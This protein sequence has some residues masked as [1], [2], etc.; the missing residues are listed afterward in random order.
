MK[1]PFWERPPTLAPVMESINSPFLPPGF[2]IHTLT[3][4]GVDKAQRLVIEAGW[5]QTPQDWI[6]FLELGH[7]YQVTT[8]EGEIVA[9]AATLPYPP[10][11][12]WIS[13]VLVSQKHRRQGIASALL[14]LCI[15]T[16]RSANLAPCLDATQAGRAVY[17]PLGFRDGLSISRWR[18][19]Q[20]CPALEL[21]PQSPRVRPLL[22]S[23]WPCI[24][25]LDH[26]AFG[27]DRTA[28]LNQLH[29]R[30]TSFSCVAEQNGKV[31][32]FLLGRVGRTAT[33]I[34]PLVAL[35]ENTALALLAFALP[36]VS[37]RVL[38]DAIDLHGGLRAQLQGLGFEYERSF[39]RM[40]LEASSNTGNSALVFA[41]SGPELG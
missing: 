37:E 40:A 2:Q 15:Q 41:I 27:A 20:R 39:T 30:S 24:S 14:G 13:M 28:L 38:I 3:A 7:A 9:T 35:D 18:L 23:D 8:S 33:Q 5:N 16:L 1:S 31:L 26:E 10:H 25:L 22:P 21:P 17:Q 19:S 29:S 36:L 4:D 12:G 6:T 11:S 34:G 32:G